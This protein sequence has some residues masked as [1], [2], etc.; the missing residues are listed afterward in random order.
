MPLLLAGSPR[1]LGVFNVSPLRTFITTS[2]LRSLPTP[3]MRVWFLKKMGAKVG[4]NCRIHAVTFLNAESGF[5]RLSIGS[6]C[7][8]GP[9]VLLDM[10]GHL[11]IGNG[12]VL[13]ARA[14]ILTHDD[15][16][17]SHGSPLCKIYP[18]AKR[19]T[20]IG[21]YC[22]VGA[23]AILVAGTVLGEQSV[24]AAGSVA[25]GELPAFG[26]YAGQPAKLKRR[27]D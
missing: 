6:D 27:L 11:Q 8:I 3:R 7:Y 13:S 1:I 20:S 12:A 14:I 4:S 16:G 9:D 23:G 25:K 17:S 24:V 18:A 15:P 26:L 21:A 22:W 19:T 10:A 5:G 2:F